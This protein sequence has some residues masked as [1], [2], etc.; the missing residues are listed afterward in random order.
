MIGQSVLFVAVVTTGIAGPDW[1]DPART[2]LIA[3]GWIIGAGGIA[4]VVG[5]I[6]ALGPS[7][8]PYPTPSE[9][10]TLRQGTAYRLVRHPIYGGLVLSALGWSLVMSPLALI[11]TALLGAMFEL[12]SRFEE[13]LLVKRYPG[14]EAYRERVR[15]RLV[16]WV[17]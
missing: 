7:L 9:G 6:V 3:I 8:T 12:K 10:S 13:T 11:P 4:L 17:H 16:P 5:G 14:Y 1:P 15:W 2:A